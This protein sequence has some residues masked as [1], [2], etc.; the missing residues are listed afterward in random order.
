MLRIEYPKGT[1]TN[2]TLLLPYTNNLKLDESLDH[3]TVQCLSSQNIVY[4]P[5]TKVQ[6]I[7]GSKTFDYIVQNCSSAMIGYQT[8]QL[9]FELIEPTEMLKGIPLDNISV[10]QPIEP[11]ELHPRIMLDEVI[12]RL[13]E[14]TPTKNA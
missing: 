10:T 3:A 8:Y 11:D 1:W 9:T 4:P 14:I 13:L 7:D 6:L 5:L 2:L 12:D